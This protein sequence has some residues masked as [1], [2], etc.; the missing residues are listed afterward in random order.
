MY[1]CGFLFREGLYFERLPPYTSYGDVMPE[2]RDTHAGTFQCR[3]SHNVC[4]S[5][6]HGGCFVCQSIQN[7][8]QSTHK[9]LQ[10]ATEIPFN[11]RLQQ[12]WHWSRFI[13][14]EMTQQMYV[15]FYKRRSV[16]TRQVHIHENTGPTLLHASGV[17]DVVNPHPDHPSGLHQTLA[18][19]RS[20]ISLDI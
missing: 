9:T 13:T 1:T 18:Y 7:R 12:C 16:Y 17:L 8:Q 11:T 10:D 5:S 6:V 2:G 15:L 14:K 4:F 19:I 20:G 3:F